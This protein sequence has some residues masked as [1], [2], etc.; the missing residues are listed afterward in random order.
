MSEDIQSTLRKGIEAAKSGDRTTARRL[1]ERVI[2]VDDNNEL[3]WIWLASSVNT[4]SERR[5]C[6]ERVLQINPSNTRARDALARLTTDSAASK[7]STD[8]SRVRETISRVRQVQSNTP[9][10]NT[11]AI[12]GRQS[13]IPLAIIGALVL[14]LVLIG[15]VAIS[16]LNQGLNAPEPTVVVMVTETHTPTITLTPTNTP[17]PENRAI[18]EVT[19]VF[20][21]TLPPTFTPTFTPIPTT[22][23][24]TATPLGNDVFT[25]YYI[26][27][28]DGVTQPDVYHIQADGSNEGM[29]LDVAR[30][31]RFNADGSQ[32]VFIRDVDFVPQVFIAA[33]DGSDNGRQLTNFTAPDTQSPSFSPDGAY[34]VFS[35]SHNSNSE[36]IYLMNADGGN[37]RKLTDDEFIDREPV[38]SPNSQAIAFTSN[39][40]AIDMTD[41][42]LMTL[43]ESQEVMGIDRWTRGSG[44]KYAASWSQDG[45]WMVFTGDRSGSG[46]IYI[47][48]AALG[49]VGD[50]ITVDDGA[51]ENRNASISPDGRV[52]A[53]ISN[54][55]ND[56]F[57]TYVV[58]RDLLSV[59][60]R[61]THNEREDI[62]VVFRPLPQDLLE[63][64]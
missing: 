18:D 42:Y 8:Q 26:S 28:N 64:N 6:L 10:S 55:E 37:I 35:S 31:V 23:H 30:D 25:L 9:T 17:T 32:I 56:Q 24:P 62:S 63:A 58:S 15:A 47:V 14:A 50:L 44:N 2:A 38:F 22:V 11:S 13:W 49:G 33:A 27:L 53:F 34:I 52:V 54:R 60:T 39:R 16:A 1:L 43:T 36:E 46:D 5:A 48:D 45:R 59:V 3:A 61:L 41:I 21:P 19:R 40:E 29:I 12:E 57:Q 7:A 20:A 4:A 51:T